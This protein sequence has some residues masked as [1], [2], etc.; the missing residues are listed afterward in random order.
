MVAPTLPR[1]RPFLFFNAKAKRSRIQTEGQTSAIVTGLKTF[2]KWLRE[3]RVKY[4]SL[5]LNDRLA[6]P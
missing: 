6:V 1:L 4:E 3:R 2:H 5:W